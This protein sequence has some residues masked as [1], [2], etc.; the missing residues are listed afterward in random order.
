MNDVRGI[1]VC[2]HLQ[3]TNKHKHNDATRSKA[4]VLDLGS[5]WLVYVLA[6]LPPSDVVR[7]RM[8]CKSTL[9]SVPPATLIWTYKKAARG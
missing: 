3:R 9:P 5:V 8:G 2:G 1:T 6:L 7:Q 4:Q